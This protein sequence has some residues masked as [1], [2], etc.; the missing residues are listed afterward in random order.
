[1]IADDYL[2]AR[3]VQDWKGTP[4]SVLRAIPLSNRKL[5]KQKFREL[6]KENVGCRGRVLCSCLFAFLNSRRRNLHFPL[7]EDIEAV[8]SQLDRVRAKM[9]H[10]VKVNV[11]SENGIGTLM[12]ADDCWDQKLDLG[13]L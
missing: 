8:A 11:A 10:L 4:D 9:Q 6:C 13:R 7:H 1:M 5:L 2:T 12:T 3:L